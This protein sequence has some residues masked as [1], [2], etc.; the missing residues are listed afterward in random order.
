MRQTRRT[1]CD[2]TARSP[3]QHIGS[4]AKGGLGLGSQNYVSGSWWGWTSAGGL[5]AADQ[6][7]L[8]VEVKRGPDPFGR[9]RWCA[10][11][12]RERKASAVTE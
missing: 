4:S 9:E 3:H 11:S 1:P 8:N 5:R 6:L 12:L 10:A 2:M 7:H